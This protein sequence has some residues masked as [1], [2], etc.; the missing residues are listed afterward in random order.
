MS[1][2]FRCKKMLTSQ[3]GAISAPTL[4]LIVILTFIAVEGVT[5]Y[6]RIRS[7]A[8]NL[9][10][11]T[12]ERPIARDQI[13]Q[14]ALIAFRESEKVYLRAISAA[15]CDTANPFHIALLSGTGCS[16]LS[17]TVFAKSLESVDENS[18][19]SNAIYSYLL[20]SG[21]TI[22]PTKSNCLNMT[23]PF[24]D[25][26][27]SNTA[28]VI[29][30]TKFKLSAKSADPIQE[31]VTFVAEILY[32]DQ[33]KSTVHVAITNFFKNSIHSDTSGNIVQRTQSFASKCESD[34]WQTYLGFN[35]ETQKCDDFGSVAGGTGLLT[36]NNEYFGYSP[37]SGK[38]VS[39]NRSV[40][41]LSDQAV[42]P[43]GTLGGKTIFP[44]YP[45]PDVIETA[46]LN[47]DDLTVI[48]D[49]LYFISSK[50]AG[51]NILGYINMT[52]DPVEYVPVC[53][54][55]QKNL[56]YG[57]SGLASHSSSDTLFKTETDLVKSPLA[58]FFLKTD[59]G[60]I[61][62][63]KVLGKNCLGNAACTEYE[64][65][66]AKNPRSN[67]LEFVRTMGFERS[68]TERPFY[69]Y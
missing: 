5:N 26:G 3:S 25:V 56:D 64:C 62:F 32:A 57:L 69:V 4:G 34:M 45:N 55:S 39:L 10:E 52:V 38:I 29:N 19:G 21:C 58:T 59:L 60:E 44:K 17:V 9:S 11:K 23:D 53:D 51:Q 66:L 12:S 54:L 2:L 42:L 63:L 40:A 27:Y 68:P 61:F 22:D 8:S 15:N 65:I 7:I 20:S 14:T 37:F 47:L 31:T 49:Q 24:L 30:G 43:D 33:S 35:M 50:S 41:S 1:S 46:M 16:G 18:T 6:I 13:G 28:T 67:D 48:R 36:Y